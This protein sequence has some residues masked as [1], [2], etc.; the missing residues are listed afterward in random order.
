MSDTTNSGESKTTRAARPSTGVETSLRVV[1]VADK[2]A[3]H[4]YGPVLRRL[5]VG[6][7]DEVGDLSLL[8]LGPS[9][10]LRYVPSP[11]VRVITEKRGSP[12]TPIPSNTSTHQTTISVP[13]WRFMDQLAPRRRL[14]SLV[15]ILHKIKPTLLHALSEKQIPLVQALSEELQIR[16]VV[17]LMA[18]T[19]HE[20]ELPN[21][22][23]GSLLC[24]NSV[25]A[26]RLRQNRCFPAERI[27]RLPIGT[28]VGNEACCFQHGERR[29]II[30]C[31]GPLDYNY[32]IAELLY[33]IKR[34]IKSGQDLHLL[35]SGRGT[36][37]HKLW[38]LV[39]QLKLNQQVHFIPPLNEII[40]V[41]DAY[42]LALRDADIFVQPWP[43][44]HWRPELLEAMS[45]GNA[46]VTVNGTQNDLII[47]EKTALTVDYREEKQLFGALD[48]LLQDRAY[49]QGLAQNAQQHLRKHFLASRM[50]SRL[51]RAYRQALSL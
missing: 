17:S 31:C 47:K 51:A 35:L 7:I 34:L 10:L 14:R 13:P 38:D 42:K 18:L 16:Y 9:D 44:Q 15:E 43:A 37:E 5:A 49:S 6:L 41:S 30:F 50:V 19:N 2:E 4:F 3:L 26:R 32:G 11:P 33:S 46:V 36:D 40:S 27:H 24:C 25:L 21:L 20:F 39:G 45:V 29:P 48:R 12:Q 8:S 28:H 1:M 22:R 23:C